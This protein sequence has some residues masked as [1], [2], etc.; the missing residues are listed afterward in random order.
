MDIQIFHPQTRDF[1][2]SLEEVTIGKVFRS[3]D[4][5]EKFG[6][7]LG[8]PHVKHLGHGLSELRI[9]GKQEVRLFF[10]FRE[11]QVVVLHG[12]IKKSMQIPLKELRLARTRLQTL[13]AT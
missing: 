8:M 10:V 5:L 11:T 7:M 4:L 6:H 13:D 9:Q 3:F 1:I 2:S 12:F